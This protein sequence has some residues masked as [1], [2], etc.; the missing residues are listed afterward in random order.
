[1]LCLVSHSML[2]M[3]MNNAG[4]HTQEAHSGFKEDLLKREGAV[5]YVPVANSPLGRSDFSP[6]KERLWTR[7]PHYCCG[8][9]W[10]SGWNVQTVGQ[11]SQGVALASQDAEGERLVISPADR[12]SGQGN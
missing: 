2:E 4:L 3:G 9:P 11:N 7:R 12:L 10:D 6:Q 5:L 8:Q 1:M